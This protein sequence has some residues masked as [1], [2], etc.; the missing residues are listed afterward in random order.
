MSNYEIT[1]LLTLVT[2]EHAEALS[3][4]TGELPVVH[5]GGEPHLIEGPPI[6]PETAE[7]LLRSLATSRQVQEFGEQRSAEFIFTFRDST[8]FRVQA[9]KHHDQIHLELQRIL[10]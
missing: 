3:L 2:T 5:L 7:R 10:A 6:T 4:H 1:D 9:R 8:Q